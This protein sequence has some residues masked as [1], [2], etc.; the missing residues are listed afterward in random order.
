MTDC[1]AQGTPMVIVREGGNVELDHNATCAADLGIA[2]DAGADPTPDA[3]LQA[4]DDV[5]E[6]S[7]A[8]SMRAA[9]SRLDRDGLRQAAAWL[10]ERL[11]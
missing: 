7:T 6:P 8:S 5:L 4:L 1:V 10:S 2:R 9:A 3:V 11:P